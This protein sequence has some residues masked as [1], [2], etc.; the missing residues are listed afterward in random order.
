MRGKEKFAYL[1]ADCHNA[2]L[3]AHSVSPWESPKWL[4]GLKS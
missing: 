2:F 4:D 1:Y 3:I